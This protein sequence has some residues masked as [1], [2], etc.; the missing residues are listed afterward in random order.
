MNRCLI[1]GGFTL[2]ELKKDFSCMPFARVVWSRHVMVGEGALRDNPKRRLRRR[3]DVSRTATESSM[4][5]F[6]ARFHACV[7]DENSI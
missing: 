4:F 6:I 5:L 7:L 3:L 2:R 1:K